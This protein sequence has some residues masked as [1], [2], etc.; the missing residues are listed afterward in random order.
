MPPNILVSMSLPDPLAGGALRV[1]IVED[2]DD[3]AEALAAN[4]RSEGYRPE[5]AADGRQA[6]A[7]VRARAPDI[8]VLDL[9]LPGLDGL[10]LLTRLRAEGH[11]CPVLILSARNADADK[12]EGFRLGADDYVTKPFRTLELMAR[13]LAMARRVVREKEAGAAAAVAVRTDN[14][15]DAPEMSVDELAARCGLTRR[16]AEVARLLARG[17]SNQEIA[18]LLDISR[19][20]ARN[21]AEQVLARLG[22]ASRF[23]V[24]GALRDAASR[25]VPR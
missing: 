15:T 3:L 2:H 21:H 6:L 22:I 4:L 12:L 10:T 20:T 14:V 8:L 25:S 19:F 9:G 7:M 5:V 24:A 11:W 17:L 16:Q 18:T 1:L 23:Q 13:L